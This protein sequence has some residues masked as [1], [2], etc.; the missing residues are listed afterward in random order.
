MGLA[1]LLGMGPRDIAAPVEAI[2]NVVDKLFTSD[3]ERLT[4]EVLL[5]RLAQQ[6]GLAQIEL[7]KLEAQSRFLFVAGWRPSVG[8]VCSIALAYNFII[9]DLANYWLDIGAAA[10]W[11]LPVAHPPALQ[12]EALTTVLLSLLGLGALRT[13]EKV[14]GITR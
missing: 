8:W 7:S 10:G 14:K 3:D 11:W 4:A 9:R 12:M 1:S 5:T 13:V 2:G 6:P